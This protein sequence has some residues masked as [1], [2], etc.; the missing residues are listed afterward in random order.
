M[1]DGA[2]D[3]ATAKSFIGRERRRYPSIEKRALGEVGRVLSAYIGARLQ[4]FG[5]RKALRI[6]HAHALGQGVVDISLIRLFGKGLVHAQKRRG[7]CNRIGR[8]DRGAAC[9]FIL[10]RQQGLSYRREG[11]SFPWLWLL[12]LVSLV[13]VLFLYGINLSSQNQVRQ[14][15]NTMT[16][17]EQAVTRIYESPDDATA[18]T[19][20]K[21]AGDAIAEVQASGVVTSTVVP[22]AA[23]RSMS[24]QKRR[25]E[26]GSTPPVGSSRKR[27]GGSCRMAH[28]SARR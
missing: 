11:P 21:E 7:N 2:Q 9:S 19:R 10:R 14:V 27:I 4:L 25:R 20:L 17:A 12:L 15:D 3:V 26:S 16:L 8:L 6:I 23:R 13:A 22:S 1:R 18:R 24:R 28:P 5:R